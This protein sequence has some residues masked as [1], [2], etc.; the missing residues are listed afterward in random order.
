PA[1][2]G[3]EPARAESYRQ[4]QR[5]GAASAGEADSYRIEYVYIERPSVSTPSAPTSP[6]PLKTEEAS[7]IVA[8]QLPDMVY[9]KL[10]R[11]LSAKAFAHPGDRRIQEAIGQAGGLGA[12]GPEQSKWAERVLAASDEDLKPYIAQLLVTPLPVIEGTDIDR[13]ARGIVARLFD[14][15]L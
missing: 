14:Y 10:F 9:P 2:Q 13:F 4:E 12:A 1:R 6:A 8:P 3:A 11:S 15:D 5:P 7:L